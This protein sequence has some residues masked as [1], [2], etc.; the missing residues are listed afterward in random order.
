MFTQ[1][2]CPR[3]AAGCGPTRAVMEVIG[4]SAASM[5][6]QYQHV[7]QELVRGIAKQVEGLQWKTE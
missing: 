6:T 3:S 4:W 1:P 7:P 5:T 2:T